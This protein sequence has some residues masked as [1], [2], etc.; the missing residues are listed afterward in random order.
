MEFLK[1]KIHL[2]KEEPKKLYFLTQ[3]MIVF[4]NRSDCYLIDNLDFLLEVFRL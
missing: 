2:W 3:L 1:D 4:L